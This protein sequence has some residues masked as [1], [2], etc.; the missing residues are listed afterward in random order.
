MKL[1]WI[2]SIELIWIKFNELEPEQMTNLE[3]ALRRIKGFGE[4]YADYVL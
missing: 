3:P 2:Q 4:F 1:I